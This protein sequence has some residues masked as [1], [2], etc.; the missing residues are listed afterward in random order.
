M[1]LGAYIKD[2]C[3]FFIQQFVLMVLLA[4]FLSVTGYPKGNTLLILICWML[5]LL[6]QV[7]WK[8]Q[9]RRRYFDRMNQ[10]LEQVDQRYL[11]GEL[12]PASYR[13]EDQIYREMIRKANKSMIE[14]VRQTEDREKEYREYI[15]SWVHEIKAPITAVDLMCVN[16]RGELTGRIRK[17]NRRIE[18][19]VD[20]ALYYARSDEV[21]KDYMMRQVRLADIV[22]E[23]LSRDKQYLIGNG[24]RVDADCPDEVYTDPKWIGF[25]LHQILQNAVKYRKGEHPYIRISSEKAEGGVRLTVEDDGIGIPKEELSR[26]FEKGFTGSNGRKIHASTGMGLYLSQKLCK[27]LGIRLYA[28]SVQGEWTKLSL[29]FPVSS[30]LSKL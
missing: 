20:M 30:Y 8:Y 4:F 27:K 29:E 19:F 17:E 26:I 9:E 16:H 15:E 18:D 11:L 21:Y 14:R 3:L 1:K 7:L 12:M 5:I 6:I 25:I 23:A 24:V 22:S 10:I 2:K 28:D 13:L